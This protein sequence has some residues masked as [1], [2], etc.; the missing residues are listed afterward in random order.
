MSATPPA[1]LTPDQER[2]RQSNRLAFT[3][4]GLSAGCGCL[5][6]VGAFLFGMVLGAIEAG[7]KMP[8]PVETEEEPMELRLRLPE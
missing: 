7:R 3:I 2:R 1:P 8:K 6:F 5:F 4:L